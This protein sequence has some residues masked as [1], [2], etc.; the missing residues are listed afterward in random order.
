M[1]SGRFLFSGCLAGVCCR[2]DGASRPLPQCIEKVRS[3]NGFVVCPEQ[4]G[5]LPTPRTP[6]M[7][8]HGDGFDVLDDK[9]RVLSKDGEDHTSQFLK[10]AKETLKLARL[11]NIDK[12]ILKEKSPSCGVKLIY[13]G[14]DLV[15]G[16]GVTAALLKREGF[17]VI[18]S[19]E[20]D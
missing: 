8:E 11:W 1:K 10:G 18:S 7:I 4:L 16:Y 20:F 14:D 17:T 12:V 5:G 2:Y 15:E 3:G 13:H 19:E 9:V 6:S